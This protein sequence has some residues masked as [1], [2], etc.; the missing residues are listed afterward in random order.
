MTDE[1]KTP[2][3]AVEA[4]VDAK[5]STPKVDGKAD[6]P[7][8]EAAAPKQGRGRG[9]KPAPSNDNPLSDKPLQRRG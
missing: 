7:K 3:E 2:E 6:A 9:A 5:E 8:A 4:K 1:N